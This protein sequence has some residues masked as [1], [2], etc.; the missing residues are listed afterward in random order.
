MTGLAYLL[1]IKLMP[2]IRNIKDLNFYRPDRRFRY[3]HIEDLF[4]GHIDWHRIERHLP[5]MLRVAAKKGQ[6]AKKGQ[7]Q[8]LHPSSGM[9]APLPIGL[10]AG[11]FEHQ[12]NKSRG[13]C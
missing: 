7:G 11:N 9:P 12:L 10:P 4:N 3:T 2:R 5:D 1:G 13:L 6:D 8:A